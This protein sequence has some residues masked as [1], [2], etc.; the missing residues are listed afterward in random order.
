MPA[1]NASALCEGTADSTVHLLREHPRQRPQQLAPG[2]E[3]QQRAEVRARD[4]VVAL[5]EAQLALRALE[6]VAAQAARLDDGSEADVGV[7][8]GVRPQLVPEPGPAAMRGEAPARRRRLLEDERLAPVPGA[9]EREGE[10]ADPA[11]DDDDVR[12]HGARA[13]HDAPRRA[14][15]P[16]GPQR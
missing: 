2:E 9:L 6:E 15:D 3:A 1:G 8:A 13:C 7:V 11:A 14:T 16:P 4:E 5:D 12:V 10:A